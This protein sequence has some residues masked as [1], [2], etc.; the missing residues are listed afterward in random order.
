MQVFT[1]PF[2]LDIALFC[3]DFKEGDENGL[4]LFPSSSEG[5]NTRCIIDTELT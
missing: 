2:T 4:G 5:I 3:A 1:V